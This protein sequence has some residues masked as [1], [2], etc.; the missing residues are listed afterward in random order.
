[1]S[2]RCSRSAVIR[3]AAFDPSKK[4]DRELG[5]PSLDAGFVALRKQTG[6]TVLCKAA[7]AAIIESLPKTLWR[8][9]DKSRALSGQ[10]NFD[11]S[12]NDISRS[13]APMSG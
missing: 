13:P 1:M 3:Q 7:A 9:P 4:I 8:Y 12:P 10:K 2:L 6:E 5:E 11:D